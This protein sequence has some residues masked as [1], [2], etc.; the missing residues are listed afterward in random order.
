M[1]VSLTDDLSLFVLQGYIGDVV[2]ENTILG[3]M[4][5]SKVYLYPHLHFT[6]GYNGDQIVSVQISTDV[7]IAY[8]L[9]G[10]KPIS[11]FR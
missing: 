5:D 3:E 1:P 7:S 8:C 6:I 9:D 2:D 11:L 10:P 4:M